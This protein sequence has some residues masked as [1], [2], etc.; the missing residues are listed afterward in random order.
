LNLRRW[1]PPII[2]MGAILTATSIP[3]RYIPISGFRFADKLVHATMYGVL[4]FLVSRAMDDPASRTRGRA[5]FGAVVF[6]I[7]L[8]AADEWHQL[9]IQ[10]R[11]ADIADWAADSTGGL[12]GAATW[13]LLSRQ[14]A[15]RTI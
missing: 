11:S 3:G 5:L 6:C 10:G 12:L 13:L 14:R 15:T 2:W 4:G 8:G 7:A 1:W 9:Y